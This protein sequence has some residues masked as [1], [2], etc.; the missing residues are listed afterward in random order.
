MSS[1][2]AYV[3]GSNTRAS[4]SPIIFNYW[5]KKYNI[6][7]E[8][9]Y[10]EIKEENFSRDIKKIIDKKDFCGLNITVPYKEKIIPYMSKVSENS[11]LIGAVNC[12]TNNNGNLEGENTDWL[13]I[14]D[15]INWLEKKRFNK[16][17]FTK[18]HNPQKRGGAIIGYGGSAKAAIYSLVEM[19]FDTIKVFNRSY[20]KI[21]N[22]PTKIKNKNNTNTTQLKA[23]KLEDLEKNLKDT[24]LTINTVPVDV[25]KKIKIN[26]LKNNN[27]GYDLVYNKKT[28]FLK[29]FEDQQSIEGLWMLFFQA[30]PCFEKWFGIK[31]ELDDNLISMAFKKNQ[32]Q[33]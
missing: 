11:K 32:N 2:K 20:D 6:E 10:V 15:S 3:I 27:Y 22:I 29:L 23:Y 16:K 18:K 4:L 7:G 33:Q 5:F 13:G 26:N 14:K 25:V 12:V 28:N 9:S 30:I 8:Y 1:K 21:K 19:N 17:M 31:P 24:Q